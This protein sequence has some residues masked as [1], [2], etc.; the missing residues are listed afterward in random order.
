M[1]NETPQGKYKLNP[2]INICSGSLQAATLILDGV[3][4]PVKGKVYELGF[5]LDSWLLRG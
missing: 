3:A 4:E 1:S 2:T 5:L